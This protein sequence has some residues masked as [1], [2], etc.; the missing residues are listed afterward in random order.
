MKV[1]TNT[2][3]LG[4]CA[5]GITVSAYELIR[6]NKLLAL[7]VST[8]DDL[9]AMIDSRCESIENTLATLVGE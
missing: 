7:S 4:I 3:L 5:A 9:G 1:D 6:A 8:Q 2:I